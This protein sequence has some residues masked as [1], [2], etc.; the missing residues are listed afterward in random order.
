M[1]EDRPVMLLGTTNKLLE[2]TM[3]IFDDLHCLYCRELRKCDR[4]VVC[5]YSFG[6]KAINT[7]V[8]EWLHE[9]DARRMLLIHPRPDNLKRRA[10]P[11]IRYLLDSSAYGKRIGYMEVGIED[12]DWNEV[13]QWL[14][15]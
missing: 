9:S 1:A 10:R 14:D 3:G 13:R 12:V 5:G 15:S 8:V 4:L 11:A 7:Q 2:Y 6:D